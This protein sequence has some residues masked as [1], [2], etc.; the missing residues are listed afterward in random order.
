M[1]LNAAEA[2]FDPSRGRSA[3]QG[4]GAATCSEAVR[5]P[6]SAVQAEHGAGSRGA[7]QAKRGRFRG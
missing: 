3:A 7:E 5:F 6:N 2:R 1:R 4:G